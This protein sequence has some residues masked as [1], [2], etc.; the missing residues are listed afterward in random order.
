M[1]RALPENT[2]TFTLPNL[3]SFRVM[4]RHEDRRP[5]FAL[6]A[7]CAGALSLAVLGTVVTR[8]SRHFYLV[9][10]L[11]L[12]LIPLACA[13]GIDG[14]VRLGRGRLA[15][16]LG[17]PWLLFLPNAPYILTDFIHLQRTQSP[18]A[19]GH[20]LLLVW[21]SFAGLASGVLSLHL[22]HRLVT[23]QWGAWTGWVFVTVTALLSGLGVALG[24]FR[25]WNSWDI[26]QQ[27]Q[28]IAWDIVRHLPLGRITSETLLPWGLGAFFGFA[29]FL[30]WSMRPADPAR[31]T[32]AE[33]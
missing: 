29:Y 8:Q 23:R 9:W 16:A 11:F 25:R 26:L 17:V 1:P 33:S 28:D 22:V 13:L 24:R 30:F 20:L 3:R 4:T 19:W 14:L 18:W 31:S 5:L 10:N 15:L 21:F 27:P 12:A 2:P 32:S 7:L 6:A